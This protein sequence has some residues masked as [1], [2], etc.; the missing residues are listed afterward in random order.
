MIE[1][2]VI[3]ITERGVSRMDFG[4]Q[5]K[6]EAYKRGLRDPWEHR[7]NRPIRTEEVLAK[8]AGT[9]I[10]ATKTIYN[11]PSYEEIKAWKTE[12]D[13]YIRQRDEWIALQMFNKYGYEQFCLECEFNNLSDDFWKSVRPCESHSDS[14]C[15]LFCALYE[16]CALRLA[17]TQNGGKNYENN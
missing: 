12:R 7:P 13:E 5:W 17:E 15:N 4:M 2:R 11:E 10:P 3:Q 14:Q 8:I 9:E 16:D 1:D 6:L